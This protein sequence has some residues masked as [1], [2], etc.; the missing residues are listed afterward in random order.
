[1]A[2]PHRLRLLALRGMLCPFLADATPK[3]GPTH[4]HARWRSFLCVR[5]LLT[6][7]LLESVLDQLP[8][9]CL[10]QRSVEEMRPQSWMFTV[11]HVYVPDALESIGQG[12]RAFSPDDERGRHRYRHVP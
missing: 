9:P 1:M 8:N 7:H 10:D 11:E 6:L 12:W 2:R 5:D 4:A 3:L